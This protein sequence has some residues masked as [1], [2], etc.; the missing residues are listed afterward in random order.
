MGNVPEV[1][2]FERYLYIVPIAYRIESE[3][4][5]TKDEASSRIVS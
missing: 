1:K 2:G 4:P 5:R 3:M